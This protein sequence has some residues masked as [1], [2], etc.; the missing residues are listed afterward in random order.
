[1]TPVQ[2]LAGL[3][4]LIVLLMAGAAGVTWQAQDWR[5]GKKLAVM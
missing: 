3:M 1:M 4:V 2:K 5:L